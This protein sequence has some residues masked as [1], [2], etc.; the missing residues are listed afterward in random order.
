MN[1]EPAVTGH[2]T[3]GELL[4]RLKAALVDDGVDPDHPTLAEL[5]PYDQFH[6]RGLAATEELAGMLSISRG[7]HILDVGSGIGGPARYFA[8]RCGCRV[9]GIDL[10]AEFC[11]VARHLTG[12]TGLDERITYEEGNALDM[13]FADQAFDGAYSMNVSMNIEDKDG[14]Y[15]EIHRVLKPGAWLALSEL[16]QGPGSEV[17]YPTPWALTAASSFLATRDETAARLAAAGFSV[18]RL[19][20]ATEATLASSAEG[21]AIVE[22]G[23]KPPHRAVGL[24]HG[25][26]APGMMKTMGGGVADGQLVPIEVICRKATIEVRLNGKLVNRAVRLQVA[27]GPVAIQSEEAEWHIRRWEIWPLDTFSETWAPAAKSTLSLIHI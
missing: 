25:D 8:D 13:P 24:I 14:L 21:R 15:R 17:E 7:D 27:G 19:D 23:G 3:S 12:L 6:G 2:D 26:L 10:T 5:A 9:T 11:E 4:A 22:A 16:A 20:D 18:E 1:T